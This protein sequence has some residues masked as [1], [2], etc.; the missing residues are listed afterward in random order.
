M[1]KVEMV[2]DSLRQDLLY[3]EWVVIL[4][5]RPVVR[6]HNGPL[7]VGKSPPITCRTY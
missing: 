5:L 6:A 7:S 4:R 2:I 3:Y 1:A